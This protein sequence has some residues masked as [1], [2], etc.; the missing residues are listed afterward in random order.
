MKRHVVVMTLVMSALLA[1]FVTGSLAE[2]ND[3]HPVST[4]VVVTVTAIDPHHDMATLQAADGALYQLPADASWKVGD[5]M[6]C[7]L[8]EP[9]LRP[10]VRMQ[11]CRPW[12]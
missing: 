8:M 9:S 1:G 3:P 12:K 7:E 10:E 5:Q 2:K 11:H 4:G 6:E